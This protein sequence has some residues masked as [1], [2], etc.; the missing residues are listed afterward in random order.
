MAQ[1][2]RIIDVDLY[3]TFP[4]EPAFAKGSAEGEVNIQRLRRLLR[5]YAEFDPV[6]GYC[7]SQ[8][9]IAATLL[10][11]LPEEKAF[12]VFVDLMQS[13]TAPLRRLF[14]PGMEET[15]AM[16]STLDGLIDLHLPKLAKQFRNLEIF[17]GMFCTEWYMTIYSRSFPTIL[18]A[19]I[20][21]VI[22][23]ERSTKVLHRIALLLLKNSQRDLL[24]EADL[25]VVLKRVKELP[26]D[27]KYW[28]GGTEA[29]MKA[30]FNMNLKKET[31]EGIQLQLAAESAADGR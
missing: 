15:S 13:S 1:W 9:F 22:L 21:D 26:D 12:W 5:A 18:V 17:S 20:V 6:V 10:V 7:Q 2:M 24:C 11:F 29:F 27:V 16:C 3:R 31:I 19:R 14:L 8:N 28:K 23:A 25:G 30:A 4:T